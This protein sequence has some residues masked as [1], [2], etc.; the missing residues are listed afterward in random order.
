MVSSKK[1]KKREPNKPTSIRIAPSLIQDCK[2]A[3][4]S[5]GWDCHSDYIRDI[6]EF[7]VEVHKKK[8]QK[9]QKVAL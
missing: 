3:A 4:Q 1:R 9:M 5:E 8:M 2:L 7:A 6:L